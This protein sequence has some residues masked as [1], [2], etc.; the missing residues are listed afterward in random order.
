MN[1]DVQFLILGSGD[2]YF[3][4]RLR[5]LME[6]HPDKVNVCIQFDQAYSRQIYGASDFFLMPSLFEPCGLSQLY[7]L[8][9]GSVPIVRKTGGLVDT[10][11]DYTENPSEGTG[12]VFKNYNGQDFEKCVRRAM[13]Y[14]Y[15]R[16][17]FSALV[18]RGMHT[19]FS[20]ADAAKKY[21]VAYADIQ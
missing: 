9:Y 7:S 16:E 4:K 21:L 18:G 3:E 11:I 8:R 13:S 20:W 2:K 14:Y 12:F 15:D 19:R 1:E 17:A 5:D 10:I 6:T